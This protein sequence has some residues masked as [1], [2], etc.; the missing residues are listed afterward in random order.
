MRSSLQR[1]SCELT[2]TPSSPPWRPTVAPS[3]LRLRTSVQTGSWCSSPSSRTALRSSLP[4]RLCGGTAAS[5]RPRCARTGARCASPPCNCGT[6]GRSSLRP[7]RRT[8]ARWSLPLRACA[9][10]ARSSSRPCETMPTHS[11][12]HP[13]TCRWMRRL[14]PFGRKDANM[15]CTSWP[16]RVSRRWVRKNGWRSQLTGMRRLVSFSTAGLGFACSSPRRAPTASSAATSGACAVVRRR[17]PTPAARW[18]RSPPRT[19]RWCRE[20]KGL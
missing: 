8:R 9:Q 3:S 15:G 11:D 6:T 20:S 13:R 1:P 16:Q 19:T 5:S 14:Q 12:S 10:T 7:L 2:G 17:W 18:S 4:R